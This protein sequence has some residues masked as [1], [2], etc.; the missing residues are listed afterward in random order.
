MSTQKNALSGFNGGE[1]FTNNSLIIFL[2]R[3]WQIEAD[4]TY[5]RYFSEKEI[6]LSNP[7]DQTI[8]CI[9]TYKGQGDLILN[10]EKFVLKENSLLF[11]YGTQTKKYS[12]SYDFWSFYWIEFKAT[13]LPLKLNTLYDYPVT[14]KE[15]DV[16]KNCFDKLSNNR[17]AT[18]AST[19][20]AFLLCN[21][22]Y[23]LNTSIISNNL[24]EKILKY[25]AKNFGDSNLSVSSLAKRH[26]ISERYLRKLFMQE[27][28]MAPNQYIQHYR[29]TIANDM[30]VHT[31]LPILVISDKCGFSD[32]YYFSNAYFKKFGI[33]PSF[34]RLT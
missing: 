29:L 7:D 10:N 3:I 13:N 15:L 27:I 19:M 11:F 9:R 23:S 26:N 4:Y 32:Q 5:Q 12:T 17:T 24:F 6:R 18:Y 25:I 33:R 30:I 14:E 16:L 1:R 28:G 2:D 8:I 31:N 22:Q 34:K 21:Y 20:F